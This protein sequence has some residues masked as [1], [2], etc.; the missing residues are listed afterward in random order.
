MKIIL[1]RKEVSTEP[2]AVH[3]AA[4]VGDLAARHGIAMHELVARQASLEEA[5]MR[6]TRDSADY[7]PHPANTGKTSQT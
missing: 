3:S 6:R 5:F 4:A 2:G 7:L 1:P